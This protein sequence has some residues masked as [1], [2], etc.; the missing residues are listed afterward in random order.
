MKYNGTISSKLIHHEIVLLRNLTFYMIY[1]GGSEKSDT[2]MRKYYMY[3]MERLECKKLIDSDI[4]D[5]NKLVI[6]S[7]EIT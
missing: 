6:E 1:V 4:S 2:E 3:Y 5:R 7:K